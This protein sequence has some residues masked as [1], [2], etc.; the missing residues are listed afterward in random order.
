MSHG[1]HKDAL[2]LYESFGR[3]ALAHRCLLL[4]YL[5]ETQGGAPSILPMDMAGTNLGSDSNR[6]A[7]MKP[8]KKNGAG[9]DSDRTP[10]TLLC[11]LKPWELTA[12]GGEPNITAEHGRNSS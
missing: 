3:R 6:E 12:V 4:W 9:S 7:P 8:V 10:M 11:P 1:F 5:G 2:Q